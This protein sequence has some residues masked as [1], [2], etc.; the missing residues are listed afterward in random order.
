MTENMPAAASHDP[1]QVHV[2]LVVP[3][4]RVERYMDECVHS[5]LSQ[6]WKDYEIVLVD[7]GSPDGCPAIADGYAQTHERVRVIHQQNQ[8]L[9]EARNAGIRAARGNFV[10]FLDGDDLLAGPECLAELATVAKVDSVDMVIGDMYRYYEGKSVAERIGQ[11]WATSATSPVWEEELMRVMSD[12]NDVRPS[13]SG[14]LISRSFLVD[15]NLWFKKG[16]YSE[17]IEWFLRLITCANRSVY[18]PSRF[19]M[20]RQDRAGSITNTL[21]VKNIRDL[22]TTISDA[23]TRFETLAEQKQFRHD[24]LSYCCYQFTIVLAHVGGMR[25]RDRRA[26]QPSLESLEYLLRY[27]SYGISRWIRRL[28]CGL[29]LMGTAKVTHRVFRLRSVL[30]RTRRNARSLRPEKRQQTS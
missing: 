21:G 14:K 12:R 13:A 26:L 25:R 18:V 10:A 9:S 19:Y 23:A 24:L 8:G 30:S 20:Y 6:T 3:L 1:D 7:D 5:V 27:D 16:I 22:M 29:G 11:R 2:S 4:Y 17:D 28:R 15:N